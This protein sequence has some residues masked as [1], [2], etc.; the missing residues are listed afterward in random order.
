MRSMALVALVVFAL[1]FPSAASA[2][3]IVMEAMAISIWERPIDP[4]V[5]LDPYDPL[6]ADKVNAWLLFMAV[7]TS[8]PLDATVFEQ[9]QQDIATDAF[10]EA[11]SQARVDAP[12]LLDGS[13]AYMTQGGGLT[14]YLIL[15]YQGDILHMMMVI[16][17][18]EASEAVA[19]LDGV[20]LATF[21]PG[22]TTQF[23]RI[24]EDV[25]AGFAADFAGSFERPFS[26]LPGRSEV[27]G[28][29]QLIDEEYL[30]LKAGA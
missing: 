12:V 21:S 18:S 24:T 8:E 28:A 9:A 7:E 17:G 29:F 5:Q 25:V 2:Q 19:I 11:A 15:T 14:T 20:A 3:A 26:H 6:L 22:R 27:P 10:G 4:G 30:E 13:A 16:S 23:P 1:L